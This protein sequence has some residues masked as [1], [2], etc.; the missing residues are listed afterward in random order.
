[1]GYNFDD[2]TRATIV[3][4]ASGQVTI[5]AR[6]SRKIFR[7]TTGEISDKCKPSDLLVWLKLDIDGKTASENLVTFAYPRE[8]Q[9]LDPQLKTDITEQNG[10]FKV[11]LTAVHP[12]LYTWLS[13]DGVDAR[14]SDNF[15]HIRPG[16]PVEIIVHPA[17]PTTRDAFMKFLKVRS[18]YDT[19]AH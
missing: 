6:S 5:P 17:V 14:C 8:L 1:M 10:D 2:A 19:Y 12:A 9:L 15:F 13:F 7:I 18:L 16:E 3:D 4:F 11:K